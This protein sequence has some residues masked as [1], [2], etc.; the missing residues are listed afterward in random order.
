[1]KGE[2]VAEPIDVVVDLPVDAFLPDDYAPSEELRLEAYRRLA[3]VTRIEQ[4]DD[5]RTEWLDRFGPLPAAAENLLGVAELRATCHRLGLREVSAT[6]REIRIAPVTL[7][8][9]QTLV[10][11]RVSPGAV[12]RESARQLVLQMPK[13]S[14]VI[15]HLRTVISELFEPD[16]E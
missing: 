1:M 14:P 11:R 5:I 8:A 6:R 16:D 15:E 13:K 12:Y 4:V 3:E 7:R 9:S 2:P 10:L